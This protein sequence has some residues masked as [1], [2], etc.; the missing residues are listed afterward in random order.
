MNGDNGL[1]ALS[2]DPTSGELDGTPLGVLSNKSFAPGQPA[3]Q[4]FGPMF[5]RETN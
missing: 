1:V 5:V 3:G 4:G 2:K